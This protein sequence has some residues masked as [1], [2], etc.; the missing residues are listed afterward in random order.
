MRS[1]RRFASSTTGQA[2]RTPRTAGWARS[3]AR[4]SGG[5]RAMRPLHVLGDPVRLVHDLVAVDEDGD[6]ALAGELVDLVAV[7]LQHRNAHLV[8]RD[9]GRPQP[10][11]ALAARA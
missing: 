11:R 5:V 1:Q 9:A 7:A 4:R 3:R 2:R 8:E 10:P 6:P